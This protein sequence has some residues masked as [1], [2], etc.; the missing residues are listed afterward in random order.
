MSLGKKDIIK[1]ISSKAQ[2]SNDQSSNFLKHFF[3]FIKKNKENKIKIS[4]FGVFYSQKTVSRIGR[5][6]I[7]KEEFKIPSFKKLSFRSSDKL[8]KHLN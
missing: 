1:N 2:I 5:N 3:S 8:K 4:N 7:S 6:P